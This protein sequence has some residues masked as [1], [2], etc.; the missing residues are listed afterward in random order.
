MCVCFVCCHVVVLFCFCLGGCFVLV[1]FFSCFFFWGGGGGGVRSICRA[2]FI[3]VMYL[4][5]FFNLSGFE[6]IILVLMYKFLV[7][8]NFYFS[9][10]KNV[11]TEK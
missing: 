11:S 6:G 7:I 2:F 8:A 9:T 1:F 5:Y 10:S 3:Y 4:H